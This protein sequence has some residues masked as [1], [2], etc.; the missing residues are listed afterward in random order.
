MQPG[1]IFNATVP[2]TDKATTQASC[3][4]LP[5]GHHRRIFFGF[6]DVTVADTFA[7]GYEEVD[8]NGAVVAG[9]QRPLTQFDP[10]QPTV[11]LPLGPGQTP[12]HETWELVQLS[13]ENHNFHMHQARFRRVRTS[14]PANS[15]MAERPYSFGGGGIV[16]DNVAARRRGAEP[17]DLGQGLQ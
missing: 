14:A 4:P 6:S 9:T 12:V 1:G 5:A 2:D 10:S 8:R 16:L 15:I 3:K 13:T 7:L 17:G 11:C